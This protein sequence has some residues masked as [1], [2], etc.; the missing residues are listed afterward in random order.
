VA[1]P[2]NRRP[3]FFQI[4]EMAPAEPILRP[5]ERGQMPLQEMI[6]DELGLVLAFYRHEHADDVAQQVAAALW[7]TVQEE[8]LR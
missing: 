7:D 8:G 3:G 1:D 5:V 6:L 2:R 4:E